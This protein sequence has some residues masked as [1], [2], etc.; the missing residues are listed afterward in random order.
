MGARGDGRPGVGIVVR[1]AHAAYRLRPAD[2]PRA[3]TAVIDRSLRDPDAGTRLGRPPPHVP[4]AAAV[5]E[6]GRTRWP[7][8]EAATPADL[9]A[10]HEAAAR[11][12]ASANRNGVPI[13]APTCSAASAGSRR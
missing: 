3:L 7:V 12:P 11:G 6:M 1:E 8:P 9:A 2:A 5:P 13:C 4:V 10:L